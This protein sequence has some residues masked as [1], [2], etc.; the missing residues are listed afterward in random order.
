MDCMSKYT[1]PCRLKRRYIFTASIL[2][3]SGITATW[4]VYKNEPSVTYKPSILYSGWNINEFQW[5]QKSES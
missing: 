1:F 4:P 5:G 3:S 2:L